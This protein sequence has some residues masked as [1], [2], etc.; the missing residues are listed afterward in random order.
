MI[1]LLIAS[2]AVL[3]KQGSFKRE[4]ITGN[5][6]WEGDFWFDL[7]FFGFDISEK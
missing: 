7:N 1:F 5:E 4:N 3:E 2:I 6:V